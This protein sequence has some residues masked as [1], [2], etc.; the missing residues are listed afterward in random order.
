MNADSEHD[1]PMSDGRRRRPETPTEAMDAGADSAPKSPAP[2]SAAKRR[3]APDAPPRRVIIPPDPHD[4]LRMWTMLLMSLLVCLPPMLLELDRPDVT[5]PEEQRLLLVSQQTWR[6]DHAQRAEQGRAAWIVPVYNGTERVDKPPMAVWLN[7]A[8]W[9]DLEPQTAS[10]SEL[11]WRARLVGLGMIV[12]ALASVFWAGVSVGDLR[13]ATLATLAAGT[14]LLLVH[15][16]RLAGPHAQVVGWLTLAV[17]AGLWAM[18]PLKAVNWFWRGAIGWTS[19]GIGIGAAILTRGAPMIGLVAGPLLL[20]I[21]LTR[22]R[23]LGNLFGLLFAVILGILLAAPW[24]LHVFSKDA[25]LL[26][27]LLLVE[28]TWGASLGDLWYALLLM[29]L[30]PWG[31]WIIGGLIQPFRW[32]LAMERRRQLLLAWGWLAFVVAALILPAS[33]PAGLLVTAVPPAALLVAQVWADH[34]DRASEGLPS[35]GAWIMGV[36]HWLLLIVASAA[37]PAFMLGQA[38]LIEAGHLPFVLLP[39]APWPIAIAVGLLL[40]GLC[41]IGLRWHLQWRPTM[42][43]LITVVW[44]LV[45]FSFVYHQYVRSDLCRYEHKTQAMW[46]RSRLPDGVLYLVAEAPNTAQPPAMAPTPGF[47]FYARATVRHIQPEELKALPQHGG[48]LFV[49]VRHGSA[50]VEAVRRLGFEPLPLGANTTIG[51]YVIY[52]PA[53]TAERTDRPPQS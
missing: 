4:R 32:Q 35:R 44:T 50:A 20:V 22:H 30:V 6:H 26:D 41:W 19:A 24:H 29:F 10:A 14:T 49:A 46:L 18:R 39:P 34:A 15:H 27:R 53:R 31:V 52:H 5:R 37:L 47:L 21:F 51:D 12:L 11:A 33:V 38:W 7:L 1:K 9:W 45:A 23:R 16:G 3:M 36:P 42:A 2:G 43:A 13:V 28:Q 8:A 40:I 48:D 17:A 25:D